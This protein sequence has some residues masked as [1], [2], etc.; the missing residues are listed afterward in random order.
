M[1]KEHDDVPHDWVVTGTMTLNGVSL[2][3][4]GKTRAEA[5]QMVKE[6]R[7]D[8]SDTAGAECVDWR[9]TGKLELND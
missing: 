3:I 5:E 6:S 1:S 2:Y 9:A 8:E 7:F 4:N